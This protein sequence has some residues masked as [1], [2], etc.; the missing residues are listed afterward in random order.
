M[1]KI[2]FRI[3]RS[4]WFIFFKN[5]PYHK[6]IAV[7]I[8]MHIIYVLCQHSY[9]FQNLPHQM[10]NLG[11]QSI[12]DMIFISLKHVPYHQKIF[13]SNIHPHHF[14][15]PSTFTTFFLIYHNKCLP[16]FLEWALPSVKHPLSQ[17]SAAHET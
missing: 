13:V 5:V 10:F 15:G 9:F 8:F 6:K 3:S 2:S 7:E 14:Y 4:S 11:T 1:F 16:Y 17:I 12:K